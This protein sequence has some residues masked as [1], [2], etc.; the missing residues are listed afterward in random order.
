MTPRDTLEVCDSC[1]S[2]TLNGQG[3]WICPE[4]GAEYGEREYDLEVLHSILDIINDE[5]SRKIIRALGGNMTP[6][7]ISEECNIP[8]STVYRK[9]ELMEKASLVSQDTR[10]EKDKTGGHPA[11]FE[12]D[13]EKVEIELSEAG[14][15]GVHVLREPSKKRHTEKE[16]LRPPAGTSASK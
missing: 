12:A 1:G 6:Q 10:V 11:T 13:F 4:C 9:L 3:F 8:I 15:L 5:G 7:E 2:E 16:R 14:E